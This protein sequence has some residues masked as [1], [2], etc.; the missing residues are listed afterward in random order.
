V[1]EPE[2]ALHDPGLGARSIKVEGLDML[3]PDLGTP[4]ELPVDTTI[5]A[6]GQHGLEVAREL[7]LDQALLDRALED[8]SLYPDNSGPAGAAP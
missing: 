7:G 2:A 8:G 4:T 3:L 1:V 6:L 5:P